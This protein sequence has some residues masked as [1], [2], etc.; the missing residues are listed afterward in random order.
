MSTGYPHGRVSVVGCDGINETSAA[1]TVG[2]LL[3]A[4]EEVNCA[5][6]KEYSPASNIVVEKEEE[7]NTEKAA[8]GEL[9]K[10]SEVEK[11]VPEKK[12]RGGIK[13]LWAKAMQAAEN[14]SE[15]TGRL[16][17]EISEEKI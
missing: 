17:D 8:P 7:E 14:A 4:K 2:L 5:V 15:A 16:L 9:F 3:A 13:V 10:E 12:R 11:V 1:T 6:A